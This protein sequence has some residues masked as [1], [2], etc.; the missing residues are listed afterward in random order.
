LS[1]VA[2]GAGW[3]RF[4]PRGCLQGAGSC[5][6]RAAHP[7]FG[8]LGAAGSPAKR[9]QALRGALPLG[10]REPLPVRVAGELGELVH[11]RRLLSWR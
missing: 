2:C 5:P 8:G 1:F 3:S 10:V 9:E 4:W 11:E 6:G 7:P